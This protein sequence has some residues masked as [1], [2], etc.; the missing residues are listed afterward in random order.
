MQFKSNYKP[1]THPS[2]AKTK[3]S[4]KYRV[5]RTYYPDNEQL[6]GDYWSANSHMCYAT[7]SKAG[8]EVS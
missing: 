3:N 6:V 5:Q 1:H 8:G 4:T 2:D 7:K